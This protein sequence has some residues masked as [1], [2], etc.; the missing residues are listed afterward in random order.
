V[1]AEKGVLKECNKQVAPGGFPHE[2]IFFTLSYLRLQDLFSVERVCK[3][4]RA[5][6]KNDVL[7]WRHLHVD[8]PLS[9]KLTND[10][11]L[12]LSARAQG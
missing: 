8:N 5:A 12:Q 4:L 7:L 2:A 6:V 3:S 9:K 1:K 11:L 10:T